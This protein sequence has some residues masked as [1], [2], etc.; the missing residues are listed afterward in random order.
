MGYCAF[1]GS[2]KSLNS[3]DFELFPP[4]IQVPILL[5]YLVRSLCQNLAKK[6]KDLLLNFLWM[7][8]ITAV[9]F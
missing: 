5:L 1:L 7:P 8:V 4:R 3:L 2:I 6:E 9:K